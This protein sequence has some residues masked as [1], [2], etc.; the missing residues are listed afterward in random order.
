MI[1]KYLILLLLSSCYIDKE[2]Q[3]YQVKVCLVDRN[4]SYRHSGIY[5]DHVWTDGKIR[6]TER[7]EDSATWKLGDC[8]MMLVR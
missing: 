3:V 7:L 6:Y 8:K 5:Y 1:T 2:I 4:T